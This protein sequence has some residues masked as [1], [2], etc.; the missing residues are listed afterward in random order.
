MI[1]FFNLTNQLVTKF[2]FPIRTIR[3]QSDLTRIPPDKSAFFLLLWEG[4]AELQPE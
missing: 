1:F 3:K 2:E 4:E